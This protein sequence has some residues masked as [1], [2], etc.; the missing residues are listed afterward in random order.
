MEESSGAGWLLFL[1]LFGVVG[2]LY[3][4]VLGLF[5]SVGTFCLIWFILYRLFGGT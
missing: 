2:F 3:P 4:P 1:G 5:I